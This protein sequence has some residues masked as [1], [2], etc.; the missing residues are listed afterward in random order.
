MRVP[1]VYKIKYKCKVGKGNKA[2]PVFR[3]VVVKGNVKGRLASLD[4]W[5][6][7]RLA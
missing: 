2:L 3:T 4:D 7:P 5:H 1:G 6:I